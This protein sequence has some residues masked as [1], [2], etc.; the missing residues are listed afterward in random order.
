M[1]DLNTVHWK[2]AGIL[3]QF[4]QKCAET[5]AF[6][7][8]KYSHSL[9]IMSASSKYQDVMR[10]VVRNPVFGVSDQVQHKQGCTATE[11]GERLEILD[12]GSR[13]IVL[14]VYTVAKTKA[15]IRS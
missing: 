9:I 15:L 3:V 5:L 7:V 2:F 1:I 8:Q 13:G 14:S 11:G 12:L 10:L 6:T 4:V